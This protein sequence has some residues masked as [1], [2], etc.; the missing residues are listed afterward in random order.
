MLEAVWQT[1]RGCDYSQPPRGMLMGRRGPVS[2]L[3]EKGHDQS[4]SNVAVMPHGI[5]KAEAA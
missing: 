1:R 5:K 3:K 4:M 2:H